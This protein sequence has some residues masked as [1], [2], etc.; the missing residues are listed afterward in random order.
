MQINSQA[1]RLEPFEGEPIHGDEMFVARCEQFPELAM[2][3]GSP[4]KA[5]DGLMVMIEKVWAARI[6]P[7]AHTNALSCGAIS[8]QKKSRLV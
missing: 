5:Y 6:S 8:R 1:I 7:K 3:D 2:A 4:Q